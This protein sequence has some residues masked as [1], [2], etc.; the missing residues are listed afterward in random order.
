MDYGFTHSGRVYESDTVVEKYSLHNVINEPGKLAIHVR[1]SISRFDLKN[2]ATI[3]YQTTQLGDFLQIN[4]QVKKAGFFCNIKDTAATTDR[5]FQKEDIAIFAFTINTSEIKEY[6]FRIT[7]KE[8]PKAKRVKYGDDLLQF[9]SHEHLAHVFGAKNV[10]K[11]IYFFSENELAKCSVLYLNTERQAVFI[12]E[13]GE[14]N[15]KLSNLL[16]GGHQM[17]QSSLEDQRFV[18]QS[19][20]YLKN[21][22]RAGMTIYELRMLNGK[23]FN[24]YSGNS[25]RTGMVYPDVSG[26][27]NFELQNV[28][29]GCMNCRDSKFLSASMMSAEE[30]ISEQRILFILS[31]I[32]SPIA[33][34]PQN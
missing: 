11:D 2:E 6:G 29:L 21:G 1:K 28:I 3:I 10:K 5:L 25:E 7:K 8:L 22:M 23:D 16:L 13:D 34:S 17:L 26:R 33:A 19:S 32:L 18:S 12:W 31:I 14:N 4:D 15:C 9:D 27:I 24:F 20:W 30:A